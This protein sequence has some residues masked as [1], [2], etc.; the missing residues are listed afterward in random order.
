MRQ[1][2]W[3]MA[4]MVQLEDEVFVAPQLVEDDFAEIA[5][6]GFRSVVNNRPDGEAADQLPQRLA[7]A[8]ARR[9]GLDFR[10]QPVANMNVTDDH[11]VDAFKELLDT[12]PRPVLFYCR[13]GTRCSILWAQ[14]AVAR[15]GVEKT[16]ETVTAAGYDLEPLRE[17]LVEREGSAL[18]G[19]SIVS[20]SRADNLQPG[21]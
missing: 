12:L 11:V 9:N 20:D 15:L 2:R 14:A 18:A 19:A 8:A 7:E 3:L 5:A 13:T 6:R 16:L 21:A 4:T 1:K 10:Y 17:H